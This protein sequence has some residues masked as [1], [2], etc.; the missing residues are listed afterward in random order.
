MKLIGNLS[1]VAGYIRNGHFECEVSKENESEI[2]KLISE[3]NLE[4]LEEYI[5]DNGELIVDDYRIEDFGDFDEI[6]VI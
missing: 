4:E 3:N 6:N 1:Y 5:R 2:S